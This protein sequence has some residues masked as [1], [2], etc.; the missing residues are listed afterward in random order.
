MSHP[1]LASPVALVGLGISNVSVRRLLEFIGTSASEIISFDDKGTDG[2][3]SDPKLLLDRGVRTL[4]VSPGYPL[5]KQWIR[6]FQARGIAV[7]SEINFAARFLQDERVVAISGSLGKSTTTSLIGEGLRASGHPYFFGGNLGF[8][9][10]DY[11]L[12]CL[13]GERPRAETL[14]L[15]LSSFQLECCENLPMH[16]GVLTF[17]C[18]NH[19]ERYDSLEQYYDTKRVVFDRAQ[20]KVFTNAASPE[21]HDYF[22]RHALLGSPKLKEVK[23]TDALVTR[24]E[25]DRKALVGEH[26]SENIAVAAAVMK[27]LGLWNDAV[28]EALLNF[29]GLSHRMERIDIGTGKPIFINDSKATALESVLTA[30][31]SVLSDANF[32][33][34]ASRKLV[35]LFGGRDKKHPWE[36]FKELGADAL[37]LDVVF[38][39]ECG[40]EARSRSG[41]EGKSYK[42]LRL[43]MESLRS[44]IPANAW[45][46]LSPGG[47]SL[48]E[49]KNF[50]DRGRSFAAWAKELWS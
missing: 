49:F 48:D 28:K 34:D 17:F 29:G 23:F 9:L 39:G 14:A 37:K 32:K 40:E 15:E 47:T 21:L 19:L 7:T 26:N 8:P 5:S 11:V 38:F 4:V 18:S 13:K 3:V 27:E 20:V 12:A 2:A 46:L 44:R 25:L 35:C 31:H 1:T 33:Q 16:V 10:A 22:A 6:D 43:A 30:V 41:L 45:V 24:A 50:E 42:T 36:K